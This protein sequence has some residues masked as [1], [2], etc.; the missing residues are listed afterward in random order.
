M[1]SPSHLRSRG[2]HLQQGEGQGNGSSHGGRREGGEKRRSPGRA[3]GKQGA[4][5]GD[6]GGGSPAL[7]A[8]SPARRRGGGNRDKNPSLSRPGQ[9]SAPPSRRQHLPRG[10]A[11]AP[12][13][14]SPAAAAKFSLRLRT[15][16][17][18]PPAR[19][20]LARAHLCAPHRKQ[21]RSPARSQAHRATTRGGRGAFGRLPARPALIAAHTL[22]EVA[23]EPLAA[24][25]A[26]PANL[27][28][29][30]RAPVE[31]SAETP[32]RPHCPARRA[33]LSCQGP[34]APPRLT[35]A[36]TTVAQCLS[37]LL[38]SPGAA[39]RRRRLGPLGR[40]S[41]RGPGQETPAAVAAAEDTPK[42]NAA[43]S[44]ATGSLPAP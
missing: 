30:R 2:S 26:E 29:E 13:A 32:P 41:F 4:G 39:R 16:P 37:K 11:A 7:P 44:R 9:A 18:E 20:P 22:G 3:L 40:W 36:G 1:Q 17:R 42:R 6:P 24:A 5:V 31:G 14:P 19:T 33:H 12:L 15:A 21:S 34:A 27:E 10:C 23:R 25:P 8:V 28:E 43:H 35:H 38:I